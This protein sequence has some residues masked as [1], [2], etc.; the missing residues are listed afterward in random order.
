[1]K[2]LPLSA[3]T[4]HQLEPGCLMAAAAFE[5]MAPSTYVADLLPPD[6]AA[7]VL[8]EFDE[9][10]PWDQAQIAVAQKD[11]CG[12]TAIVGVVD[13][14]RRLAHRIRLRDI[15]ARPK[16]ITTAV[17]EQ[18][19]AAV[20]GFVSAEFGMAFSEIGGVE[21][22][23]YPEGGEFKPHTDTHRGNA[24]RAFTVILYLNDGFSGGETAFPNLGYH[25]RP[26]PGRVLLFLP[27]ELH[28][29]L[30][31]S[32]GEKAVLVFWVHFPGARKHEPRKH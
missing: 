10:D 20:C 4:G 13:P 2:K 28:A 23:R 22:I 26:A 8:G 17:V 9:T 30:P 14:E 16:P 1:M 5:E 24:E 27:T 15:A 29:G 7:A 31:V 18:L 25:C 19:R 32:G 11:D 12:R 21:I 6:F 3:E